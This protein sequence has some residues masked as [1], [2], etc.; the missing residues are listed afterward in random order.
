MYSKI[1]YQNIKPGGN[2]KGV[3]VDYFNVRKGN[4]FFPYE[5]S[6]HRKD[7]LFCKRDYR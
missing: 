7:Q 6:G 3:D 2:E 4:V 5:Q 1:S